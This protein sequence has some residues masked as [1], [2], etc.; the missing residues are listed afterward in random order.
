MPRLLT[1]AACFICACASDPA[2]DTA[3]LHL[4]IALTGS[5]PVDS[6]GAEFPLSTAQ[7]HAANIDVYVPTGTDC[8]DVSGLVAE[9]AQPRKHTV[10]CATTGD[11][12]RLHGPWAIDL[13]SGTTTPELPA[14]SVPAGTIT[15]VVVQLSPGDAALGV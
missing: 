10:S 8:R 11:R 13:G 2:V 12:V 7:L 14:F 1:L 9:P 3:E 15:R 4:E 6:D 5:A